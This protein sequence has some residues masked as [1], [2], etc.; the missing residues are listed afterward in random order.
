MM[1]CLTDEAR[2][3]MWSKKNETMKECF[4]EAGLTLPTGSPTGATEMKE[5]KPKNM[6]RFDP[7]SLQN[8]KA[9]DNFNF[10]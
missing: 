7:L 6:V 8:A 2:Q 5:K 10:V 4:A 9:A 1:A 3:A